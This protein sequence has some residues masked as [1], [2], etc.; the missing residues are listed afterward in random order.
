MGAFTQASHR[1]LLPYRV[2]AKWSVRPPTV[3]VCS[4]KVIGRTRE[5][6]KCIL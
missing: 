4:H 5:G 2:S 3:Q 1:A 6:N